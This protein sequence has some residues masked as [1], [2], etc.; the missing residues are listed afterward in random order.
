M[1]SSTLDVT[2][3]TPS[4]CESSMPS[5]VASPWMCDCWRRWP[6]V[7]GTDGWYDDD[8]AVWGGRLML[9]REVIWRVGC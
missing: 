1:A 5:E 2:C 9:M 6:V 8:G 4:S 3:L 7:D